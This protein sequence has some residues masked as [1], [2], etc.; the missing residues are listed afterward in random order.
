[1]SLFGNFTELYKNKDHIKYIDDYE[2]DLVKDEKGKLHKKVRYI[3]PY[4]PLKSDI[5]ISRAR[6]IIV[7]IL[8]LIITG[9]T[10]ASCLMRHTTGGWLLTMLPILISLFPCL[11]LISGCTLL[12]M[13]GKPMKRDRY[14][15]S[16][17]RIF[18]SCGGLVVLMIAVL[19]S[20]VI[21]RLIQKDW[22]FLKGDYMF[23]GFV[24]AIVIGAVATIFVLRGVEVDERQL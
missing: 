9:L 22:I 23:L 20:E 8:S 18:R 12:P 10:V 19:V 4:I 1:M 17:I 11:Y 3:G 2:T 15:H 21:Y 24:L 14:M 7:D 5:G 16:I 13:S 6:F